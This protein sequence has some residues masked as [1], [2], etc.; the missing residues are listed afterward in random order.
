[1]AYPLLG[2]RPLVPTA[3]VA[4]IG[5]VIN[6]AADN[7]TGPSPQGGGKYKG[8]EIIRDA[9]G[10][11]TLMIAKGPLPA[12]AWFVCDGSASVTPA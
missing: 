6:A 3:D 12:D 11:Y 4:A 9:S 2:N 5:S 1:M 8:M 10:T 7:R